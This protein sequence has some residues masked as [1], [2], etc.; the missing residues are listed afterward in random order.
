[1]ATETIVGPLGEVQAASTA[2]GGTALT[3]TAGYI[4]LPVG[5]KHID[6]I[7]RN[8]ATA[9][10]VQWLKNPWLTILKTSDAGNVFTDYSY[11][12]QDGST[13]TSV[14]LSLLGTLANGD[15]LYVGSHVPFGGVYIDVD[16]AN[17]NANDLTVSYWNGVAW[18]AISETDNTDTG[19]ALAVDGTV[20]WTVP[21]DWITA[22]LRRVAS[23]IG[24]APVVVHQG[25]RP[26]MVPELDTLGEKLF[27]TRW[28]WSAAMDS[29]T[30]LDSMIGLS[31][32]SAYHE[33][34]SGM[35]WQEAVTVGPGGISSLQVKTDAGTANLIVDC[36][37]R[38]R[39]A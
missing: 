5:T 4:Q 35:A 36:A 8:F 10:V 6:L 30:T 19:A 23:A 18:T 12:A 1:M 29:A 33:I 24:A 38:G 26:A 22:E 3:T 32:H 16:G 13:S 2:G 25:A 7:P 37:A 17:G 14:D 31:R 27:W 28:E 21:S 34:P 9:V 20:T 11:V 15:A 39:F